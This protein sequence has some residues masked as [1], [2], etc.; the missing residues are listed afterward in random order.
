MKEGV[1]NESESHKPHLLLDL[2]YSLL[3]ISVLDGY[4]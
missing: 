1:S 2:K 4:G 3:T